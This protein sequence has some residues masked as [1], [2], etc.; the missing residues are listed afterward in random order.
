LV[1]IETMKRKKGTREFLNT[2]SAFSLF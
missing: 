2:R 1:L